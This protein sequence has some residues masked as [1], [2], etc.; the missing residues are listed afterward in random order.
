MSTTPHSAAE[1]RADD[2]PVAV[3]PSAGRRRAGAAGTW[4]DDRTG[5]A[6]AGAFLLKKVF[7][8]HWTFMLGEIAMYS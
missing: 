2:P 7:P 3:P 5:L 1:L 8:D 4:L 6:R